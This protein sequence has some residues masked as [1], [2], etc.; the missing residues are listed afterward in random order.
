MHAVLFIGNPAVVTRAF[1]IGLCGEV[2][3]MSKAIPLARRLRIPTVQ[4]IVVARGAIVTCYF[5]FKALTAKKRW[6]GLAHVPVHCKN[7]STLH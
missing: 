6:V 1:F 2:A 7:C 3:N 4:H 5:M